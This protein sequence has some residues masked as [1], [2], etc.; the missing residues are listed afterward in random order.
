MSRHGETR[1][2][3]SVFPLISPDSDDRLSL[4]FHRFVILYIS[5]DT[6]SVGLGQY[7]YR[8]CI[9]ALKEQYRIG[10][11]QKLWRS[12]IY[13]KLTRSNDDDSRK[14]PLK[15]FCLK[16]HIWWETN[17]LISRLEFIAQGAFYSFLFWHRKI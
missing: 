17:S 15:Y 10:K 3:K 8:K 1:E 16:L 14:H 5:C 6:R 4:N 9:M 7:C 2:N 11:K 13:I 12:H